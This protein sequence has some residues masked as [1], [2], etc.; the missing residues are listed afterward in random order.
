[1]ENV[2]A[3]TPPPSATAAH[4]GNYIFGHLLNIGQKGCLPICPKLT[5][6]EILQEY[7]VENSNLKGYFYAEFKKMLTHVFGAPQCQPF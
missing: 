6:L 4:L 1:M 7:P 3:P 5:N 2:R